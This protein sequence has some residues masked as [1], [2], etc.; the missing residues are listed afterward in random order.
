LV[1]GVWEGPQ[2]KIGIKEEG[3][4]ALWL[5]ELRQVTLPQDKLT[6]FEIGHY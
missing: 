1:K 4:E 2:R 5:H 3:K 6:G